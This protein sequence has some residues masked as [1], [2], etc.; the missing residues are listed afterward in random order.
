MES[1]T[2]SF[3][4]LDKAAF[5]VLRAFDDTDEKNYWWSRTPQERL[6]HMELLRHINYG[7]LASTRLQRVL[8]LA[9]FS[10]G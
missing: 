5:S 8:E 4:K 1:T 10:R 2:V 9:E 6:Q 7:H 3:P